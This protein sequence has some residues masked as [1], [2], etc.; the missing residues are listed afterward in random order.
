MKNSGIE[1][2]IVLK[3]DLQEMGWGGMDWID[4]E[5]DGARWWA[6]PNAVMDFRVPQ[7]E[8]NFLTIR[9]PISFSARTLRHGFSY[10]CPV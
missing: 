2:R 10:L 3:M 4:L 5:Q 8:W 9:A 6:L 7:N 1:E